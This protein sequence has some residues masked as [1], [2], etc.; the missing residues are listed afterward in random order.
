M[1]K[2]SR[3]QM[4]SVAGL[5]AGAGIA[6]YQT[7]RGNGTS[8]LEASALADSPSIENEC[9]PRYVPISP[10]KAGALVYKIYPEGGCM[11]ATVKSV[12]SLVSEK[13]SAAVP[14]MFFDMFKYGHAGCGTWGTLCGG[15][16]GGAAVLGLFHQDKKV[17]DGLIGQL[18]RWYETTELPQF[19][20]AGAEGRSFPK[21]QS[22]SVLCHVSVDSWCVEAEER[23]FSTK[24]KERCRRLTADVAEKVVEI[25]N[26]QHAEDKVRK[27]AT[28]NDSPKQLDVASQPPQSCIQCHST[29][30]GEKDS[31]AAKAPKSIVRMEC[32][33][34]HDIETDHPQ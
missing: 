32:S 13:D 7:G 3:R 8:Y 22:C 10:D 31:D 14:P 28:A 17:R 15:C 24:R 6:A 12:V 19:V 16:N 23:P 30:G 11:Y 26:A 33:T 25:L 1:S 4:L 27:G 18:F 34:C 5:T 20:P 2:I 21:T 29:P 9:Q